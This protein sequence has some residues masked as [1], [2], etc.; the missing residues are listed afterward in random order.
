MSLPLPG[1]PGH[2]YPTGLDDDQ[3]AAWLIAICDNDPR[4]HGALIVMPHAETDQALDALEDEMRRALELARASERDLGVKLAHGRAPEPRILAVI[5][6]HRFV[7]G[8]CVNGCGEHRPV[9]GGDSE[10]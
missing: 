6:E 10:G 2:Q 7:A 8:A 1:V 5:H 3:R 4:H 9:D